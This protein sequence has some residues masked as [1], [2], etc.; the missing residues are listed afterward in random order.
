MFYTWK[1]ARTN[2]ILDFINDNNTQLYWIIPCL[3]FFSQ[4]MKILKMQAFYINFYASD[5]FGENFLH[6]FF[7][8]TRHE[9]RVANLE[10]RSRS[11]FFWNL[12]IS[13][14]SCLD[15]I[16]IIEKN[17][18][19]SRFIENSRNGIESR[20]RIF[21]FVLNLRKMGFPGLQVLY[22][23]LEIIENIFKQHGTKN[24]HCFFKFLDI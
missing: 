24:K 14:R 12:E 5:K 1:D 20:S 6:F 23:R 17:L 18:G 11:R 10:S 21:K 8:Q 9:V 2:R 19:S 22:K 16:S 3:I 13:S 7:A 15:A 4:G